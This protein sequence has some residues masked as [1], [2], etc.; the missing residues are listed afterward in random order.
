MTR[1][2]NVFRKQ[3]VTFSVTGALSMSEA[4]ILLVLKGCKGS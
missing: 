1:G 2:D 3:R 4:K